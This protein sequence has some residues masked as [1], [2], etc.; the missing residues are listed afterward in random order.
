MD[1]YKNHDC[2]L[3]RDAVAL[4]FWDTVLVFIYERL[5]SFTVFNRCVNQLHLSSQWFGL[6]VNGEN[7]GGQHVLGA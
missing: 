3:L 5:E 7:K 1:G 4:S 2:T 6:G